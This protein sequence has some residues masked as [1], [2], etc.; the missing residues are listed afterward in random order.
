M[1]IS[2][3][4]QIYKYTCIYWQIFNEIVAEISRYATQRIN[5]TT[6]LKDCK[7][8]MSRTDS[9]VCIRGRYPDICH[10]HAVI[11]TALRVDSVR[12]MQGQTLPVYRP[13]PR[14]AN[15]G[16]PMIYQYNTN[17]KA[18]EMKQNSLNVAKL[19]PVDRNAIDSG[20]RSACPILTGRRTMNNVDTRQHMLKPRMA[21]SCGT[22]IYKL[23]KN[24]RINSARRNKHPHVM[25]SDNTNLSIELPKV[26][27]TENIYHTPHGHTIHITTEDITQ[28]EVDAIVNI[29]NERLENVDGVAEAIAAAAGDDL[30][31][32]CRIYVE[33]F[34]ELKV[35]E[36]VVTTGYNLPCHIVHV[37]GPRQDSCRQGT[38]G[39]D[40]SFRETYR[41]CLKIADM[42]Q[43]AAIAIPILSSG[44]LYN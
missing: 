6:V 5:L 35:G 12:R 38:E 43:F 41:T 19:E 44:I 25:K 10:A 14:G 37:V 22:E 32:Y 16:R 1:C 33:R 27:P 3:I 8:S 29:T 31:R 28:L 23:A 39:C 21:L 15:H 24:F 26:S 17:R 42:K 36:A 18:H 13:S 2:N 20:S 30:Q 11:S 4:L 7:V 9:G 34:G 40:S